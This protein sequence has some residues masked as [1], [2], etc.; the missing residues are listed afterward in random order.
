MTFKMGFSY[1]FFYYICS[2]LTLHA[3]KFHTLPYQ[4]EYEKF[5]LY[6]VTLQMQTD[7][8]SSILD[9]LLQQRFSSICILFHFW[10]IHLEQN[11]ANQVFSHGI[12]QS[13]F[14][15]F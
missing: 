2:T 7:T 13:T 10:D 11:R 15:D 5:Q 1:M 3:I 6:F 8:I 12:Y 9:L 14:C 4:T